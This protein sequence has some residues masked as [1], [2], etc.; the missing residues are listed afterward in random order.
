MLSS[1]N[2]S[3]QYPTR[4]VP[5]L[6]RAFPRSFALN[7]CVY[8]RRNGSHCCTQ[9]K[10]ATT[11]IWNV[12]RSDVPSMPTPRLLS[13]HMLLCLTRARIRPPCKYKGASFH[14]QKGVC[15]R[16]NERTASPLNREQTSFLRK[17]IRL[18]S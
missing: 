7:P 16:R 5:R 13:E 3:C 11:F 14:I 2:S 17:N 9:P 6:S 8:F 4:D 10:T 15:M 1:G 12:Q 18:S